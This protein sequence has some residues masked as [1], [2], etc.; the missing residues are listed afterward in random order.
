MILVPSS[1]RRAFTLVELLVVIAIIAVLIGLLLPAVQKVRASA[2]RLE[3]SNNLKQIG[4][5]QQHYATNHRNIISTSIRPAGVTPPGVLQPG[6]M[7]KN[8]TVKLTDVSDGLSNTIAV[9]ESAGRPQIYRRGQ[10]FGTVPAQKLNGGGWAR[11]GSDLVFQ[12][13]TP[14]GASF[15]G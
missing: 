10:P 5:A 4:I 15:P 14:D 8:T 1:R 6:M 9:V 3:C 11:P 7:Q 13:S 12:T 2:A